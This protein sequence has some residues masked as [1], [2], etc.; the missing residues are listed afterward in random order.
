MAK[1]S[2]GFKATNAMIDKENGKII[3]T[4]KDG[5]NVFY[6]DKILTDWNGIE[7]ISFSIV[8]NQEAVPDETEY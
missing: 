7:G 6:I 5:V 1:N 3:E 8:L 4:T 2:K